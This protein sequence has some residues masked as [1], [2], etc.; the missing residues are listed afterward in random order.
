MLR[1][2]LRTQTMIAMEDSELLVINKDKFDEILRDFQ[3]KK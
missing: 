2:T 1:N 3:Q